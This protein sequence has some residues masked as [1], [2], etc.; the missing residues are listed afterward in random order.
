MTS[1]TIEQPGA[2]VSARRWATEARAQLA[3]VQAAFA[4]AQPA[5]CR[6]LESAG[7]DA[8]RDALRRIESD[9]LTVERALRK[10]EAR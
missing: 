8:T 3:V 1:R 2:A 9:L 4:A 6:A 5:S 7:D 10:L